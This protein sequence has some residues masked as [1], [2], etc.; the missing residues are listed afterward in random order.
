[1]LQYLLPSDR[2]DELLTYYEDSLEA[3]LGAGVSQTAVDGGVAVGEAAAAAMV[4][5]R[6]G[7]GRYGPPYPDPAYF[8]TEGTGAGDWRN[9]V[10]PLSPMGNNFKWVGNVDPFLIEDAADFA[11]SGPQE[12]TSARLRR[13]VQPGEVARSRHRLHEDGR[14]VGRWRCSGPTT[15]PRCGRGSP[16]QLSEQQA[17]TSTENARYFAMLYLTVCGRPDRVLPGQGAPQ[18]LAPSDGDPAGWD[19]RRTAAT[20]GENGP[21]RRSSG[22]RPI[23]ITR[24]GRTAQGARS[25]ERSRTSSGRIGCRSARRE[26]SSPIGPITRSFTPVLAGA[27]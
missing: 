3:I 14:P 8:F 10:A 27:A 11:T 7:D 12:L 23:R 16:D 21:G 17:L 2:D 6:T 13:R 19:R 22:T 20:I 15:R 25:S 18:F 26:S 24:P 1:M 4:T 5:A 9:L